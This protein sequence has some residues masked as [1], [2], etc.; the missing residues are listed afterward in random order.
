M[1]EGT[2]ARNLMPN[3]GL[4][5][6][7]A[8][9]RDHSH[10]VNREAE[11]DM[12]NRRTG[13]SVKRGQGDNPITDHKTTGPQDHGPNFRMNPRADRGHVDEWRTKV[14]AECG[15]NSSAKARAD[16]ALGGNGERS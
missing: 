2:K 4:R 11:G 1:N 6:R 13:E 14:R 15:M 12:T 9:Q 8:G 7:T 10:I 5:P 16:C 3:A